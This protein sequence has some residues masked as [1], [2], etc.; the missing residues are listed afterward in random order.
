M[1][2][3]SVLPLAL[4]ISALLE[5]PTLTLCPGCHFLIIVLISSSIY[6]NLDY[7]RPNEHAKDPPTEQRL[8][9]LTWGQR[10]QPENEV[11]FDRRFS[12]II[13]YKRTSI[14]F[15]RSNNTP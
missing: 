10:Y 1:N 2:E 4:P 8:S 6:I 3:L 7:P 9:I 14:D 13:H 15:R 5:K 12:Q 11:G